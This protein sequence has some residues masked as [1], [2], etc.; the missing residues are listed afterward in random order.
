MADLKRVIIK[1]SGEALSGDRGY[2]FDD[3]VLRDI[4]IN[5]KKINE[6]GIQIGIVVGGGNF[7][8]GRS[9][10]NIDRSTSDQIGMLG[11]TMNALR[12]EQELISAGIKAKVLT[13]LTME[14]IAERFNNKKAIEYMDD[15]YVLIFGGGTGLPFFSTDTT[16][17]LRACELNADTIL[18]GK[19]GTDG[20]YD[21]DPNKYDDAVKFDELTFQEIIDRNLQVIDQTAASMCRDEKISVVVFGIDDANNLIKI[22]N[23]ENIGTKVRGE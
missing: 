22:T 17:A 9:S 12:I 1:L 16:A 5:I 13:S 3:D 11:T 20:V 19:N 14:S 6:K 4:A 7:W 18:I 21:K 8:R 10:S 15:G 2:G 23:G